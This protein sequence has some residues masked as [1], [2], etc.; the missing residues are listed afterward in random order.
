MYGLAKNTA[1]IMSFFIFTSSPKKQKNRA[2][3]SLSVN[4][5]IFGNPAMLF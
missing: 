5:L 4:P 2:A 1:A 3:Y